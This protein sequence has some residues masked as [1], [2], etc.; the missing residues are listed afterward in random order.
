MTVRERREVVATCHQ[1]H[2]KIADLLCLIMSKTL[3]F[4]CTAQK[5]KHNIVNAQPQTIDIN[6]LDAAQYPSLYPACKST[7][8]PMRAIFCGKKWRWCSDI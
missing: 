2:Y 7:S 1:A 8:T 6:P 4:L 3:S 5:M